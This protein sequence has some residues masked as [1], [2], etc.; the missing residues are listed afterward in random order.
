MGALFEA[1]REACARTV[2]SRGGELARRRD[3]AA[4]RRRR[5]PGELALRVVEPGRRGGA[6]ASSCS[7][8]P[9][10]GSA[11]RLARRPLRARRRRRDRA[12][13]TA[14]S[15]EARG[16]PRLP[17]PARGRRA[18]L[19][20]RGGRRPAARSPSAA[21]SRPRPRGAGAAARASPP[22]DADQEIELLL[23]AQRAGRLPRGVLHKLVAALESRADVRLDGE[24]VRASAAPCEW[25]ARVRDDG[26]GFRLVLERHP[27]VTEELGDGVVLLR[28]H[29]ARARGERAR[30]PRARGA[31]RAGRRFDAG[32]GD[33]RSPPRCCPA[34][35]RRIA[36]VVETARLPEARSEPPRL[37][38]ETRREGDG[39]LGARD[40]R[41][42]RSAARAGRR[43][44]PGAAARRAP[45]AR[46]RGRGSASRRTCAAALGLE[47]GRA[48]APRA[49]RGPRLR[50]ASRGLPRQRR[51]DARTQD[52]F[53][54]APLD[55]R[56]SQA[57]ATTSPSSSARGDAGGP[58][59]E[60][61]AGASPP[62]VAASRSSC[63]SPAAALRRSRP[64]GS[65]ATA[66]S[67]PISSPRARRRAAARPRRRC[68]T[69]RVSATRSAPPPP[70]SLARLR[71]LLDGFAGDPRGA[72]ARGLSAR[73]CATTSAA[74][75]DWLRFLG[76]AGLGALLADD[77]GLGK[78][79]QALCA[80]A[81]AHP[82][83]R[84]DERALRLGGGGRALSPRA[85][86]LPLPRP[87]PQ[88]RPR[89]GPHLHEL[90]AAAP[91]ARAPRGRRLGLRRPRRGPVDQEPGEPGRPG[92]ARAA[93]A[94]P[95]RAH[96]NAGREP[97]R[98][99]VE[100]VRTS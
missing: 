71:P 50:R 6:R 36:V 10:R 21:P 29:A 40:P 3:R 72:A 20:A 34:L 56:A 13:A 75:L 5:R 84:A 42:R 26:P 67:S 38:V 94:G 55:R 90:R 24:P 35:R 68:P 66:P 18:R 63:R 51:W 19:R 60:A 27:P 83:R 52:F 69:S 92:R 59:V 57:V 25:R 86:P 46:R 100:P 4:R 30:R 93:R 37:V 7:P 65:R 73:S 23:G 77:M 45:R 11:L 87:G 32:R 97:P 76:D 62:G 49:R 54:A 96:G 43:R 74:A 39:A 61:G 28:R 58:R 78:T 91:R 64:T 17:L 9:A 41:L 47:P 81:R 89:S 79:L 85:A 22:S 12:P 80:V 16:A 2:W 82:R 8:R 70:P 33:A 44:A 99:A 31:T 1:V 95:H 88:P 15:R 98:G 48:P 14:G 53:R